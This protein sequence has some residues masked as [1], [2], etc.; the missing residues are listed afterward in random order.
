MLA[1]FDCF[2]GISGDM[3]LGA[4]IDLGVPVE[5]LQERLKKIPLKD[6][7]ITVE[8]ILRN[9]LKA[10][11][12]YVNVKND[13]K[14]RDYK[15]IKLLIKDS[16]LSE[17]VKNKSLEIFKRIA[18]AEAKIHGIS[19]EKV[20]FHEVG[21]I[22]AIVDIV[23][24]VLCLEYLGI[25]KVIASKIP[26]GR[27]FVSCSHGT[28]PIPAP[29]TIEILKGIP[30]YGTEI[31]H[32]L[33]TPTGAAIIA[34]LADS[35]E[36][37][38]QMTV[39]KIGY[40]AGK[41]DLGNRPNL[42]RVI[43]GRAS[44]SRIDNHTEYES[45]KIVVV[46]TCIDDMNPEIFGFLMDRLFAA[47]ALDVLWIPVFMKKNR[48]GTMI[49]VLCVDE[50]KDMVID[51]ILSETTSLGIRYYYVRRR[52]LERERIKI[53]TE[54]GKQYVKQ[55]KNLDGSVRIIP[56]YEVC[57]KIAIEKDIPI[58]KVYDVIAGEAKGK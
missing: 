18:S 27:G 36:A 17:G 54:Y 14:S 40:G 15:K 16:P 57:R 38:P 58:R 11:N 7:G 21:G 30:V 55:V 3:T 45:D 32:E 5:W 23:G 26:L 43:T 4:L 49:Q 12:V 22:D 24:T 10:Q 37:M 47:G 42:L 44:N 19:I 46:E 13:G 53:K 28:L 29:A 56:E 41:N 52:F 20:H 39:E 9:G 33:V 8:Q 25:K 31:E 35:F 48:P 6:F 50:I 34:T 51:R 1:Y 2:S